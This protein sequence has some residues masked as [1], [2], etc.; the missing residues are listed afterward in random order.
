MQGILYR[1]TVSQRNPKRRCALRLLRKR[2]WPIGFHKANLSYVNPNQHH[3]GNLESSETIRQAPE[4]QGEDMVHP[5]WRHG[6]KVNYN[7]PK[8]AKFLVG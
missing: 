8:V 1:G 5:S 3:L 4:T 7:G 2:S 6:D